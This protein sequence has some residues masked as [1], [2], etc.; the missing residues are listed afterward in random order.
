MVTKTAPR[1]CQLSWGWLAVQVLSQVPPFATPR[2]QHARLPCPS[3]SSGV[4]TNSCPLNQW[5]HPISSSSVDPSPPALSLS[6]H[7]GF[8]PM[9]KEAKVSLVKNY[10]AKGSYLPMSWGVAR[11]WPPLPPPQNWFI[12]RGCSVMER[13]KWIESR[14]NM[15]KKGW[16]LLFKIIIIF[17]KMW[18]DMFKYWVKNGQYG[19]IVMAVAVFIWWAS[20]LLY[21][22][23]SPN[24]PT[25]SLSFI[26]RITSF[27]LHMA[28]VGAGGWKRQI[29]K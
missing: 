29:H 12:K 20:F 8:S 25:P 11:K 15:I 21:S 28:G 2:L 5:C 26:S 7:Q 4:C 23:T 10:W 13:D 24:F 9:G 27:W 6:Q 14:R 22:D 17:T 3:L 16:Y 18:L 19:K 1:H